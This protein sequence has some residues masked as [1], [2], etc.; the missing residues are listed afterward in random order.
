[1]F[2]TLD[3]RNFLVGLGRFLLEKFI[4]QVNLLPIKNGQEITIGYFP[5]KE[6]ILLTVE[7]WVQN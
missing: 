3:T 6:E 2:S 7:R 5:Y 1:M 4:S